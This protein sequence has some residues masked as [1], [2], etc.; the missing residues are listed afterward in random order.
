MEPKPEKDE[1]GVRTDFKLYCQ[2]ALWHGMFK[3]NT[4]RGERTYLSLTPPLL[5]GIQSILSLLLPG[6]IFSSVLV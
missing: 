3:K 1:K 2:V 5:E 6:F 4:K